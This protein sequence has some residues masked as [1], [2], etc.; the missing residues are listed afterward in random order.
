MGCSH[1]KVLECVPTLRKLSLILKHNFW[2][3]DCWFG[4]V[5]GCGWPAYSCVCFA[6]FDSV[7]MACGCL[8]I[9]PL[10]LGWS[11]IR[12]PRFVV[13]CRNLLTSR[14]FVRM[15]VVYKCV[16]MYCRSTSPARTRS[17]I[18]YPRVCSYIREVEFDSQ[19]V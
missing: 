4:L 18:K 12:R 5:F 9:L 11:T 3:P 19:H 8:S 14:A 17:Q 16:L 13:N 15:S 7:S 10:K 6:P 1:T 2:S